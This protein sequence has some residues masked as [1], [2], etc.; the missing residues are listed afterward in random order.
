MNSVICTAKEQKLMGVLHTTWH[1]LSE[2]MPYVTLADLGGFESIDKCG[3]PQMR[4]LT[5][6]LLRKV[7]PIDGDYAKAGWSKIQVDSLW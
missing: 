7:M 6:A 5:A 3:M 4:T 1:T 2:G